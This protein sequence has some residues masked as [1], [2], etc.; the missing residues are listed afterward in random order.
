MKLPAIFRKIYFYDNNKKY[1]IFLFCN[2]FCIGWYRGTKGN[3]FYWDK[4]FL[5]YMN[6]KNFPEKL[7]KL[8]ESFHDTISLDYI[9]KF[10]ENSKSWNSYMYID[11]RKN[12][13]TNYDQQLFK[14]FAELE[15]VQPY[16]DLLTIDTFMFH[17]LYG[18]KDLPQ[19]VLNQ[20][21]GRAII[22]AGAYKGDTLYLFHTKFNNS[23][24]YVY[25]PVEENI[26]VINSVVERLNSNRVI[27]KNLGL[28]YEK[29]TELFSFGANVPNEC[30]IVP[31]DEEC[32]DNVG[33]IKLDTEGFE[34]NIIKGAQ[35]VIQRDKPVLVV[36][37]YHT[38][39]DFFELKDII[40]SYNPDY[41]FII[42]RSEP[43]LPSADLVLIA[44]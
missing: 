36:A 21:D 19:E 32:I 23:P 12:F 5:S 43:I 20:I 11:K 44:Y 25:E 41:R 10:V 28:G 4:R 17:S 14:E 27:I 3:I 39:K 35:K 9:N 2:F 13:W 7:K 1:K 29:R 38:P 30:S 8:K 18:L 24:I 42:R 31:L 37:M 34:T 33:L 22:D 16:P 40:L 26:H 15:F 6:D